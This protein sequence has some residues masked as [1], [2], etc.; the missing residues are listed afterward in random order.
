MRKF[1]IAACLLGLASLLA[2]ETPTLAQ[3]TRKVVAITQFV[4][5]PELDKVT[6]GALAA[7]AAAGFDK[8]NTTIVFQNAQAD[9]A[10]AAQIASQFTAM[11]PD[12]VIAIA[13]PSAQTFIKPGSSIPLVFGAVSAPVA[14]GLVADLQHPGKN[15]TGTM[16]RPDVALQFTLVEQVAP[17]V[18]RIGL[19]YNPAEANSKSLVADFEKEGGARG[20]EVVEGPVSSSAEIYSAA[21]SLVDRVD[22]ICVPTDN[23]VVSGLEAAV[24]IAIEHKLPLFTADTNGVNRGAL[25]AI[26]YDYNQVG[27]DTGAIAARILKGE[28]PGDIP[29]AAATKTSIT[30]NLQTA[31]KIGLMLPDEVLKTASAVVH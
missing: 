18:K 12:V 6:D 20:Y 16:D 21:A 19:L 13:T 10:T 9:F 5:H 7:L 8:S 22:A 27:L 17:S 25:A 28:K 30:F 11:S 4:E 24:Q 3:A 31:R 15:V 2:S 1:T 23:T 29:V 14:S 26:G